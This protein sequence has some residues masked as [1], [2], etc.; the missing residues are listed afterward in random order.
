MLIKF[1]PGLVP[2]LLCAGGTASADVLYTTFG[3][4]DSYDSNF[5][6]VGATAII[7][8]SS[9]NRQVANRFTVSSDAEVTGYR[10][11]ISHYD[12]PDPDGLLSLWSGDS[13]PGTLLEAD[14]P[15]VTGLGAAEIAAVS[16]VVHPLLSPGNTYWLVLGA[17]AGELYRWYYA[18]APVPAGS[19]SQ[20]REDSDL[21]W[22]SSG[23]DPSAF[24]PSAFE[25]D[26]V[27]GGVPEPSTWLLLAS[28]LGLT[29]MTRARWRA[30]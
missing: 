1:L 4:G 25:V 27:V 8:G 30:R 20:Y 14:I 3:T 18:V 7:G 2:L 16:S 10:V 21:G 11:A 24:D 15:F 12:A 29:A 22:I 23:A 13:A 9:Q 19:E 28:V 26:G 17:Q 5:Q 6:F